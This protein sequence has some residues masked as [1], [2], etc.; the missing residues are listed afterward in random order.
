MPASNSVDSHTDSTPLGQSHMIRLW[1]LALLVLTA[2][3]A[4]GVLFVKFQLEALRTTVQAKIEERTG[5]LL[6]AESVRVDGL[7]GLRMRQLHMTID[8]ETGPTVD[9][10][11]PEAL[12]LVSIADLLQG[13]ISVNRIQLDNA[14]IHLTRPRGNYWFTDDL[15]DRSA[16]KNPIPFRAVG[17]NCTIEIE[18]IVGDTAFRIENLNSDRHRRADSPNLLANL[19]GQLNEETDSGFH[20][21][22]RYASLED[23]EMRIEGDAL[24]SQSL[25]PFFP[26][27]AEHIESGTVQPSIRVSGYPRRRMVVNLELPFQNF[28]FRE[29]QEFPVPVEGLLTALASYDMDTHV[30]T[31]NTARTLS[32]DF[33]GQVEGTISFAKDPPEL[34]L[35]LEVEHLAMSDIMEIATGAWLQEYGTLALEASDPYLFFVTFKGDITNTKVGVEAQLGTGSLHFTPTESSLPEADLQFSLMSL[36]WHSDDTMPTGRLSLSDGTV[37]HT[38]SG[39]VADSIS[40]TL[41]LS[42]DTIAFTPLVAQ[43]A[44]NTIRGSLDYTMESET[45]SLELSG[46][47][48]AVEEI[49]IIGDHPLLNMRGPVSINALSGTITPRKYQ[50]DMMVD[51]TRTHIDW[52]WWLSKKTGVGARIQDLHIEV[53][54]RKSVAVVGTIALDTAL[55]EA[56]ASLKHNG[57]KWELQDID[58]LSPRL[59]MGTLDKVVNV[60][61]AISGG[62][63]TDAWLRWDRKSSTPEHLELSTGGII[64]ELTLLPDDTSVP[65]TGTLVA[66]EAL[67]TKKD[68]TRTG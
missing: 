29:Q 7:R 58:A 61:Y 38:P 63:S 39:F 23:F 49:G 17:R 2:I 20:V 11:V 51:L 6:D 12:L 48:A 43:V 44:G 4:G 37:S 57:R 67:I 16:L 33:E 68:S 14:R 15:T 66:V 21:F 28:A 22:A 40:G 3:V 9:A 42:D 50:F 62:E 19:D 30:L 46:D 45:L 65:I 27:L 41:V 64:D 53:V 59:E 47:L 31:L 34:D 35:K 18:H 54:P 13:R 55:I 8:T 52:D 1:L 24:D 32:P 25:V 26:L 10:Y 5:I 56:K 60:P 36:S